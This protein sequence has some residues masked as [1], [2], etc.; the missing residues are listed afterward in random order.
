[1]YTG[2]IFV[3]KDELYYNNNDISILKNSVALR[4]KK[5]FFF[6]LPEANSL[7]FRCETSE[8]SKKPAFFKL[9]KTNGDIPYDVSDMIQERY[10]DP[11]RI[12]M[13]IDILKKI[14]NCSFPIDT[15][16]NR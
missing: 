15:C 3:P 1:M 12:K 6:S 11:Q 13:I 4:K 14:L 8:S 2:W 16:R 5:F 9:D 7:G 10:S